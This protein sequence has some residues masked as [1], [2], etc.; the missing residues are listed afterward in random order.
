MSYITYPSDRDFTSG[1]DKEKT[2]LMIFMYLL[3]DTPAVR[4]FA[5]V[6]L[7][8]ALEMKDR[9]VLFLD[10]CSDPPSSLH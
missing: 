7:N 4:V 10:L 1:S 6:C 8:S 9:P 2:F 5:D 3:K